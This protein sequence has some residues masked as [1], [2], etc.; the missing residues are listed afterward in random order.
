MA[1][2]DTFETRRLKNDSRH[3]WAGIRVFEIPEALAESL[4]PQRGALFPGG[5]GHLAPVAHKWDLDMDYDKVPGYSRLV[6]YYKVPTWEEWLELNP[7]H[8]VLLTRGAMVSERK[9]VYNG[10]VIEGIDPSD[11]TG[12]TYWK[13]VSGS[14]TI[15]GPRALVRVYAVIYGVANYRDAFAD[16]LGKANSNTMSYFGG[17][18]GQGKLRFEKLHFTPRPVL[19]P[20]GRQL[21]TAIYDFMYNENGWLTPCVSQK[22]T[23]TAGRMV[24][25]DTTRSTMF[26]QTHNFSPINSLLANSWTGWT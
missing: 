17:T 15:N 4:Q 1:T 16:H 3:G 7:L 6:V 5:T 26:I 21:Y 2:L 24:P 20:L 19:D 11:T 22:F 25:T 13:V 23:E 14:N 9:R 18:G 12:R 10:N 8:G